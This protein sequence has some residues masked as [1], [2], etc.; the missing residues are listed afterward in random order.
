METKQKNF[1]FTEEEIKVLDYALMV[2]SMKYPEDKGLQ[3]LKKKIAEG[4]NQ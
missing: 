4:G 1:S 3:N 2:A